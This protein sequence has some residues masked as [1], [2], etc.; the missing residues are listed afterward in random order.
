MLNQ[1]LLIRMPRGRQQTLCA[2]AGAYRF[3]VSAALADPGGAGAMPGP[4]CAT[5]FIR[6][7]PAVHF[8]TTCGR[9]LSAPISG[10]LLVDHERRAQ[11]LPQS[12]SPR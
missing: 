2:E 3:I 6:N 9:R 10:D 8:C 1:E 5:C 7:R 11:P 12:G 4:L